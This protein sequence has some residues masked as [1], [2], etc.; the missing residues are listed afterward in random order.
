[1]NLSVE[2]RY[3]TNDYL[4]HNPT[5][6]EEDAAPKAELVSALLMS[7]G[8]VPESIC[9][10]GCGAGRVL[11]ELK[12]SFPSTEFFGYDIAPNA[13]EFWTQYREGEIR[14]EVGNFLERNRRTYDVALLLD[15]IEH[16]SD[17]G[18]FLTALHGAAQFYVFHI[19]L[20]LS[21]LGVIRK[22]R[23]LDV[24]HAVGHIHYFTK[25]LALSL[26]NESGYD[27]VHWRYTGASSLAP[28]RTWKSALRSI[29]QRM[30]TQ[31]R[32]WWV[33]A[34]GGETLLVLARSKEV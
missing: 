17:P 16:L 3:L 12:R 32:D 29:P 15:V 27:V 4:A 22:N 2:N 11:F 14:F 25:D 26:L 23:L 24:R 21:A 6:H 18:G 5:W 7:Q 33:R 28:G 20:D 8:V 9:D 1:M 31:T 34:L 19:P 13:A 10:I 30:S